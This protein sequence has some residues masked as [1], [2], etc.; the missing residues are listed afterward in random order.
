MELAESKGF[1]TIAMPAVSAGIFGFP[2]DPA[3]GSSWLRSPSS[4]PGAGRQEIDLYLMDPETI[5]FF[6]KEVA[7]L[8]EV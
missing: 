2:K 7:R 1:A 5:D 6:A 4:P 3:P 8:K